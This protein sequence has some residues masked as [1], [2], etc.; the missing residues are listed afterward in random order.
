[1]SN[2]DRARIERFDF[3][4]SGKPS[5]EALFTGIHEVRMRAIVDGVTSMTRPIDGSPGR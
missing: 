5:A 2:D 4:D 3:I 1:M